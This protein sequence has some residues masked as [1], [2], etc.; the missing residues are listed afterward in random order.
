MISSSFDGV[1]FDLIFFKSSLS[2]IINIIKL[3]FKHNTIA[4]IIILLTVSHSRVV[5]LRTNYR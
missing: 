3:T 1:I 4:G 2:T 5:M